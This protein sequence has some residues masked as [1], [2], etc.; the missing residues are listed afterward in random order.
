[1][2]KNYNRCLFCKSS[3][4]EIQKNQTYLK[5]F[6]LRSIISDLKLSKNF[7]KK[8][9][10]YK[11]KKCKIIQNNPWF[12]EEYCRKIYSNI[13]G[14]HH[15]GWTNLINFSIKNKKPDHGGLFEIL[16]QNFKPKSYAEF[17]SPFMGLF[18]NFLDKEIKQTNKTKF[19][20][21][22]IIQYL[23]SRQVA[24]CSKLA[25][26]KSNSISKKALQKI[27]NFRKKNIKEKVKKY[28]YTDNSILSWGQNDNFRS[29]NSKSFATEFF[30]L[31][32]SNL[33]KLKKKIDLFGI[34]HTLDHTF[35]PRKIFDYAINNSKGVI[36]YCH[37]DERLNKQHLF[38]ITNEFLEFLKQ[39]KIYI[40]N[41]TEH[42]NKKYNSPE[43]YF[44]CSK[45][46][47]YINKIKKYVEKK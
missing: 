35:E 26:E 19:F 29:V 44:L 47:K 20:F 34:F 41:L 24:G 33:D 30:N 27:E 12:N 10:V 5:N 7:L 43:L 15:R 25:Q 4:F 40:I 31:K 1:M 37:T 18:F 22:S 38:S 23:S 2:L 13:Y 17:N 39:K 9:K 28:L 8:I 16:Y 45:Q 32:I 36:I 14:Q 21:N 46:K 42:I 3:K 6:Y 11:C